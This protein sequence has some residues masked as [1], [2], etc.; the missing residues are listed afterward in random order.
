MFAPRARVVAIAAVMIA[1]TA[2]FTLLVRIPIPATR[3]QRKRPISRSRT[4][5][6]TDGDEAE[7]RA[8]CED[9]GGVSRTPVPQARSR[10]G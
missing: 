1:V 4:R 6:L 2:V 8:G 5:V 7:R 9:P 10:P 3:D